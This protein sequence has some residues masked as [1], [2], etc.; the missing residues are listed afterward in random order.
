ML[1]WQKPHI[2][3]PMILMAT[4]SCPENY[5]DYGSSLDCRAGAQIQRTTAICDS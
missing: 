3:V 4:G 1:G 2:S 5:N